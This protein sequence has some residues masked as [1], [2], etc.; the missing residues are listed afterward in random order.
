LNQAVDLVLKALS[1]SKG[2]ETYISKIP[3]FKIIDLADAM[4]PEGHHHEVGIREGEKLHEVMVT[5][6]DAANTYEYENY[7]IIYPQFDWWNREAHFTPGGNR[8]PAFFRYSS[9]ENVEWLSVTDI[10]ERLQYI[11]AVQ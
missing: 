2:G 4:S 10:R 1:E 11:K 3:S 6:Y 5:E 7:F 8:V 9:D